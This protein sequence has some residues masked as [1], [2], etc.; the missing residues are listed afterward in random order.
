MPQFSVWTGHAWVPLAGVLG[1][2]LVQVYGR[3]VASIAFDAGPIP[4]KESPPR[5]A[6]RA[7]QSV[8]L[9]EDE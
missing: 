2:T 9:I 6:I 8:S 4:Q 5:T 1:V 7:G 3:Q